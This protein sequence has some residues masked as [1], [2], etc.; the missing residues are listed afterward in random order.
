[1]LATPARDVV[2]CIK[3]WWRRVGK[4]GEGLRVGYE[5]GKI[6]GN[7]ADSHFGINMPDRASYL[8]RLADLH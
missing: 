4:L 1:L 2:R 8:S 6:V 3:V 7:S 5:G